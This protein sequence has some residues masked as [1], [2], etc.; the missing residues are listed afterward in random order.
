MISRKGS[1]FPLAAAAAALFT[2]ALFPSVADAADSVVV[3]GADLSA[4]PKVTLTV[5]VT[6]ASGSPTLNSSAFTVLE[7]SSKRSA[8]VIGLPGDA[9][10][11][12]LVID[13]SGSMSGAGLSAAKA[14][15][16]ALLGLLPPAA[17]VSVT[18]F[19]NTPYVASSF[20]TDRAATTSAINNL[21]ANGETAL[22]DA[23]SMGAKS[24]TSARRTLVVLTDGRDTVSTVSTQ[25][26]TQDVKDSNSVVYG[27]VLD[28][29]DS[30]VVAPTSYAAAS[31]GQVA[32]ATDPG[33][34]RGIFTKIGSELA[35]QY[36]ISFISTGKGS[37]GFTVRVATPE[38]TKSG[39]IRV[40]LPTSPTDAGAEEALPNPTTPSGNTSTSEGAGSSPLLLILGLIAIMGAVGV[41]AFAFLSNSAPKSQL[42]GGKNP[43][44][45]SPTMLSEIKRGA[46]ALAEHSLRAAEG[47][48]A[49]NRALERAGIDMRPA[50]YILAVGVSILVSGVVGLLLGQLVMAIIF[51]LIAFFVARLLLTRKIAKRQL[52]FADQLEQTLPLLAGSLRAGFSVTQAIDAVARESESPTAD[53]FGRVVTETR[54]GKDL[55]DAL[56]ALAERTENPDFRWVVQAMEIHRAVG[57]DLAEVLDNVFS[58]IRDRNSVRRQIQA[59]GAEGRLSAAVLIALPFGA[60]MFIQLIN[61]GYLG[62]LFQSALGWTLLITALV[63]IGIGSLWIKRLLKVEY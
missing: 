29:A 45:S 32:R 43:N 34:L 25:Q 17:S 49:L 40:N 55:N 57:G 41:G 36:Q 30:D 39:A 60:A 20:T 6:I 27:V 3:S 15:A 50:E 24:F 54:L 13:T 1:V 61:P 47:G 22:N 53:E 19:G 58:T 59:L 2:A 26:A 35:S 28:T 52:A 18:G 63:S 11:V 7:T 46:T 62:L 51:A 9:S 44:S 12:A 5:A 16:V 10:Q 37:T 42:A 23:V 38:G 31:G 14:A 56:A 21:K 48:D 8:K 4:A 33:G